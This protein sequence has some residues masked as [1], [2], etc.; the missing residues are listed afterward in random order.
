MKITHVSFSP[1]PITGLPSMVATGQM[2]DLGLGHV[3]WWDNE[4]DEEEHS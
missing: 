1:D 4:D 2:K 3:M